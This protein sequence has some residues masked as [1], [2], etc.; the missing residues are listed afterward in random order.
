[1]LPPRWYSIAKMAIPALLLLWM[2]SLYKHKGK[3]FSYPGVSLDSMEALFEHKLTQVCVDPHCDIRNGKKNYNS[4]I[5]H[6]PFLDLIHPF[7]LMSLSCSTL[8][9][10]LHLSCYC[11][12][13]W[14]SHCCCTNSMWLHALP[15]YLLQLVLT[16]LQWQCESQTAMLHISVHYHQSKVM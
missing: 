15:E 3:L 12:R 5:K 4:T 10:P 6:I 14:P 13:F 1:M 11:C 2:S 16:A 9:N 7:L 8:P